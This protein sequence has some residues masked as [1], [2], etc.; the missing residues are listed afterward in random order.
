M[1]EGLA[2][3]A[4]ITCSSMERA[5]GQSINTWKQ[6]GSVY[7]WRYPR[8][9]RSNAGWH[10]SGDHAGCVN[11]VSLFEALMSCDHAHRTLEIKDPPEAVWRNPGFGKP[12]KSNFARLR[13]SVDALA[14][15]LSF[16]GSDDLL[17][18]S[19]ARKHL[20]SLWAGFVSLTIGE[21]DFG[22]RPNG[23][24]RSPIIMFWWASA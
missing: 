19:G 4:G 13:I 16:I 15:E 5:V 2:P 9:N 7:I 21:G 6:E 18:I 8:P 20:E 3:F 17:H 23:H 11:I 1:R 10:I 22:T 14:S 24:K 12:L